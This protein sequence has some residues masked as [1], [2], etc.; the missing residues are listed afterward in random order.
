MWSLICRYYSRFQKKSI[1]SPGSVSTRQAERVITETQ[2]EPAPEVITEVIVEKTIESPP[3]S[4]TSI[5]PCPSSPT[6]S[7]PRPHSPRLVS[8]RP[9]SPRPVSPRPGQS[10]PY[11]SSPRPD[12]SAGPIYS[13]NL[14]K[15][16]KPW[17]TAFIF[18]QLSFGGYPKEEKHL[19]ELKSL[20]CDIL[21]N[22]TE[23]AEWK[24]DYSENTD[25]EVLS[26]PIVEGQCPTDQHSFRELIAY[27]KEEMAKGRKLYLHCKNGRGRSGLMVMI[28]LYETFITDHVN[29]KT[30]YEKICAL[31]Y[32][33]HRSGHGINKKWQGRKIPPH[34]CQLDFVKNWIK[35]N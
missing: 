33:A 4:P 16:S 22:L 31:V 27:L 20:G 11:P 8:P 12:N 5:S 35:A 23:Q 24:L 17:R 1:T 18:D 9:H 25:F 15:P 26:Y 19:R 7:S 34:R 14:I 29:K 3:G 28:L 30:S 21:L 2:T 32:D 6:S 13:F 10:S